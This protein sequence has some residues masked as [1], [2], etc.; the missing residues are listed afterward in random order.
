MAWH[1]R[2]IKIYLDARRSLTQTCSSISCLYCYFPL[3]SIYC[4]HFHL[5]GLDFH[6]I[7][8]F[9][10]FSSTHYAQRLLV[11]SGFP[12]NYLEHSHTTASTST[13][14]WDRFFAMRWLLGNFELNIYL[15]IHVWSDIG[16]YTGNRDYIIWELSN[17]RWGKSALEMYVNSI[18][19][20]IK[21]TAAGQKNRSFVTQSTCFRWI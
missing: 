7:H 16:Y 17:F 6:T 4:I 19:K 14:F 2:I 20:Y 12:R 9:W 10:F 11:L 15:C 3:S 8:E 21:W 13:F 1:T 5:L 18:Y